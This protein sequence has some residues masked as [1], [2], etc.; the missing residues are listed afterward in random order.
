MTSNEPSDMT[1]IVVGAP[2]VEGS[3][4]PSLTPAVRW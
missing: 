1:T 4:R 3:P 2:P